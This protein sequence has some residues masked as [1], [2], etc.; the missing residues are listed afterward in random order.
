LLTK[1]ISAWITLAFSLHL[2]R[3]TLFYFREGAPILASLVLGSSSLLST[4]DAKSRSFHV[5]N[6]Q[7]LTKWY[8]LPLQILFNKCYLL[9][10]QSFIWLV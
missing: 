6:F 9:I 7:N 3:I 5:Y 2:L 4:L 10:I 8:C 1:L